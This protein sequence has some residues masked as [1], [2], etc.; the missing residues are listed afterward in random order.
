MHYF[1]TKGEIPLTSFTRFG[2]NAKIKTNPIGHFGT[3]LKYAISIILR[4][5]G[6]IKLYI[7]E[8][9]Y[10]FYLR[11]VKFRGKSFQEIRMRKRPVGIIKWSKSTALPFT[12]ELGKEWG[13]W[14]AYRE[15]ESN[16]RDEEEGES[17]H[18]ESVTPQKGYTTILV[19]CEGFSEAAVQGSVFID[20]N[21]LKLV[22]SYPEFDLYEGSSKYLYCRGVRVYETRN[23]T[24]FTYDLKPSTV[25]LSEDRSAANIWS[26]QWDITYR[27]KTEQNQ[28]FLERLLHKAECQFFETHDLNFGDVTEE[29]FKQT[30]KKM[31]P[32]G[33]LGPAGVSSFKLMSYQESV[34]REK[35]VTLSDKR[36]DT[37]LN[38]LKREA[39]DRHHLNEEEHDPIFGILAEVKEQLE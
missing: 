19:D 28:E 38:L 26:I 22:R 1:K 24:R 4:E 25:V 31:A 17:G 9:E 29:K 18:C 23:P 5:G 20:L 33:T 13:L 8:V 15:L 6:T 3:G 34:V 14:Q 2:V 11:D 21:N 36:W 32:L 10:E 12:T 7:N 27:F 39:Q 16:T 37:I 35:S 30:V